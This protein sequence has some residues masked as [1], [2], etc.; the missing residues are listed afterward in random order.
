[1]QS[2]D[3]WEIIQKGKQDQLLNDSKYHIPYSL[4]RKLSKESL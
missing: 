2:T 4:G 3:S 1:M